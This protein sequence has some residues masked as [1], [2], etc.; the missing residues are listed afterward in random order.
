MK[1]QINYKRK[2][3]KLQEELF[4]D[5]PGAPIGRHLD[6]AFAD[7]QPTSAYSEKELC[8]ALEK[9]QTELSLDIQN[10]VTDDYVYRIQEDA[11]HLF[12]LQDSDEEED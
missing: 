11:E 10:V 2:F 7:Y 3:L 12:D 9:Y 1:R 4:R 8:Y 5:Y 6:I